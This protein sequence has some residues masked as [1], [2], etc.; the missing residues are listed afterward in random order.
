MEFNSMFIY[1]C[2]QALKRREKELQQ[3]LQSLSNRKSLLLERARRVKADLA[4]M[5]IEMNVSELPQQSDDDEDTRSAS[6]ATGT[7][8]FVLLFFRFCDQVVSEI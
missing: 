3:H 4:E 1:D 7:L 8:V 2:L 6:T 5:G